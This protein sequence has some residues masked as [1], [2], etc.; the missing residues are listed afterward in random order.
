MK[1]YISLVI[2]LILVNCSTYKPV[3][4]TAG[5]SGTFN[6][7]RA[8]RITDDITLCTKFAEDTLSDSQEFQG[9]II[10][11][12]LRPASLGVVSKSDDTRKN[13]IRKCLNN[14]GHSV[15]N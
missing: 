13:Y 2:F 15:L 14:R 9:W 6:E 4:D 12:I 3:I 1:K 5:R 10:D 8:E 11:N 7:V